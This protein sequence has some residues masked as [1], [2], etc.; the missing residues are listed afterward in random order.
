MGV[1]INV[2]DST[3]MR[4]CY[5]TFVSVFSAVTSIT[6]DHVTVATTLS[7]TIGIP[8]TATTNYDHR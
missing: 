6:A 1:A 7:T 5:I 2:L 4:G 8:T 3:I